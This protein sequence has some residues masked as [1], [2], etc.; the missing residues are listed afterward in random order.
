MHYLICDD[1]NDIETVLMFIHSIPAVVC[2]AVTDLVVMLLQKLPLP[3]RGQLLLLQPKVMVNVY[4]AGTTNVVTET[5]PDG[6]TTTVGVTGLDPDT[7]F[8]VT[9]TSDCG[10]W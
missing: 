9:V 1:T 4:E 3:L 10:F 7:D 8:E 6:N 5:L 2:D